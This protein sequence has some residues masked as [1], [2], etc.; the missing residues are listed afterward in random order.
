MT[1]TTPDGEATPAEVTE[2]AKLG[3]AL[4]KASDR[5]IDTGC[6]MRSDPGTHELALANVC[7]VLGQI[8]KLD[9]L[10]KEGT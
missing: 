2:R 8:A 6:R 7:A 10:G 4:I 3:K 1:T 5:A 9:A